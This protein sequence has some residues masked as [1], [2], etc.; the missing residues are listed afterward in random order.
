MQLTHS[1]RVNT[2]IKIPVNK[3]RDSVASVGEVGEIRAHGEPQR[4]LNDVASIEAEVKKRK[5]T[6]EKEGWLDFTEVVKYEAVE[7]QV[8]LNFFFFFFVSR[9]QHLLGRRYPVCRLVCGLKI[10]RL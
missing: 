4:P 10:T 3:L 7:V 1:Y 8:F 6:D 5:L 9:T 2:K